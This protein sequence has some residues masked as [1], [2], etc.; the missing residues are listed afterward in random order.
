MYRMMGKAREQRRCWL[1][2]AMTAGRRLNMVTTITNNMA[3]G[4]QGFEPPPIFLGHSGTQKNFTEQLWVDLQ[5]QNRHAFIDTQSLPHGKGFSHHIYEALAKCQ[6]GV[7]VLSE[8][9][10]SKSIW[11]M[12][13][14]HFF[15]Q[16]NSRENSYLLPLFFGISPDNL[17]DPENER[18][19]V[20]IW[21]D[22][23]IRDGRVD[24]AFGDMLL[25]L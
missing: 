3:L 12:H 24:E 8:E 6:V 21:E 19:W 15:L 9:F 4:N 7:F 17:K 23:A 2:N 25:G 11:P 22:W 10:F 18:R 13:E 16:M 14:L 20:R 5:D 1:K